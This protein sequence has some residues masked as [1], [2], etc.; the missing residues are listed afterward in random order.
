MKN[1]DIAKKVEEIFAIADKANKILQKQKGFKVFY[2]MSTSKRHKLVEYGVYNYD[3]KKYR[4]YNI[5]SPDIE[6][7]LNALEAFVR[8]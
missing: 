7:E 3:T 1:I 8:L 2:T 4:L 6:T 5:Y